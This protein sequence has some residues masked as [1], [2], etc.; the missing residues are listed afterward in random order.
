MENKR[1]I[2][3]EA[4]EP[5][6]NKKEVAKIIAYYVTDD[7]PVGYLSRL[8]EKESKERAGEQCLNY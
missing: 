1:P 6:P 3:S 7:D 4:G 8:T 5:A 2:S